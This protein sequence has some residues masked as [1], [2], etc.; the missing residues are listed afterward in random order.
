MVNNLIKKKEFPRVLSFSLIFLCLIIIVSLVSFVFVGNVIFSSNEYLGEL[1]IVDSVDLYLTDGVINCD[2]TLNYSDESIVI[3]DNEIKL[4]YSNESDGF[5]GYSFVTL[6]THFSCDDTYCY[7]IDDSGYFLQ[8][9]H[10]TEEAVYNRTTGYEDSMFLDTKGPR[11]L[12]YGSDYIVGFDPDGYLMKRNK[13]SGEHIFNFTSGPGSLIL[14]G[15]VPNGI[16]DDTYCY[17]VSTEGYFLKINHVT[18]EHI[19]N[20][21]VSSLNRL[22][23]NTNVVPEISCDDTYCYGI[24]DFGYFLKINHVTGEQIYNLT[25]GFVNRI[26]NVSLVDRDYLN[27]D[28][29]FSCDDTYCYGLDSEFYFLKI[30]HITGEQIYNKTEGYSNKFL[31]Y[32]INSFVCDNTYCYMV[33]DATS[34]SLGYFLKVNHITGEQIYNFTEGYIKKLSDTSLNYLECDSVYCHAIDEKYNRFVKINHVTGNLIFSNFTNYTVSQAKTN[35]ESPLT[36]KLYCDDNYC[37]TIN[38]LGYFIKFNKNIGPL[39]AILEWYENDSLFDSD[40]FYD[41]NNGTTYNSDLD[42]S[43]GISLGNNY[44]C[45]VIS[46]SNFDNLGENGSS[47]ELFLEH[48]NSAI[49]SFNLTQDDYLIYV[50][51]TYSYSDN[52]LGSGTV[53]IDWYLN[54]ELVE[55]DEVS[56]TFADEEIIVYFNSSKVENDE[57]NVKINVQD[58]YLTSDNFTYYKI[59]YSGMSNLESFGQPLYCDDTYCYSSD[60]AGRLYFLKTNHKTGEQIFDKSESIAYFDDSYSNTPIYSLTCDES[61][62][63]GISS[64]PLFYKINKETGESIFNYT[65]NIVTGNTLSRNLFVCD[66]TYCYYFDRSNTFVKINKEAGEVVFSSEDFYVG[67]PIYSLFCDD[68]YCYSADYG[69]N[70]NKINHITGE[71]IFNAESG[72]D[73]PSDGDF[74]IFCDDTYCYGAD[75]FGCFIKINS[76]TGEKIFGMNEEGYCDKYFSTKALNDGTWES[77]DTEYL[78]LYCDETHCYAVDLL[79][80]FLK[81]NHDTGD[82][83]MD[84]NEFIVPPV[85]YLDSFDIENF[86]Y[87]DGMFYVVYFYE[88]IS[89]DYFDYGVSKIINYNSLPIGSFI[90]PEEPSEEV[91]E[92]LDENFVRDSSSL[93]VNTFIEEDLVEEKQLNLAYKSEVSLKIKNN[94][95]K[96][97]I[98]EIGNDSATISIFSE[99]QT[100]QLSV[101]EEWKV[102]LDNDNYYDLSVKLNSVLNGIVNLSIKSIQEQINEDEI[103]NIEEETPYESQDGKI[104]LLNVIDLI[105]IV[106]LL[107]VLI[108]IFYKVV[109]RKK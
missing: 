9:N 88:N 12:Y 32:Q 55:S 5:G 47:E 25:E 6:N 97:V 93:Q 16:C 95:H 19:Y 64:E 63:Y 90:I 54:E 36:N 61:Y 33:G 109:K 48:I 94:N 14:S 43:E 41:L 21:S 18:G 53:Y 52:Y 40:F 82:L 71:S 106:L 76:I 104:E 29:F 105:L 86:F 102:N 75:Y 37:Y 72:L 4:G 108:L 77:F 27:Q 98:D 62:C 69:G 68:T 24:D 91:N 2:F 65:H 22:Y 26:S 10:I 20:M 59:N 50:N 7:S 84:M 70:F 80:N 89:A 66:D 30:N 11:S 107:I 99:K 73:A 34:N 38:V 85:E 56:N 103:N 45:K 74:S 44:Y 15:I 3:Q 49:V 31:A 92:S 39:S 13:S 78:R 57:V 81:I 60:M 67:Y 8:I 17:G 35:F 51:M 1:P 23:N 100:K 101:G 46:Y 42:L 83:V 87:K 79:G 58:S 28:Q 96:L